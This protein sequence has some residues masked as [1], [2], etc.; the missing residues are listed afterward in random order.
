V[1][2]GPHRLKQP[3]PYT[4]YGAVIW[5]ISRLPSNAPLFKEWGG[6]D[7]QRASLMTCHK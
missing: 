3:V 6:I 5:A 4:I 7:D 1:L 2:Q